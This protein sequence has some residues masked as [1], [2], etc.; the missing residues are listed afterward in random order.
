MLR[1]RQQAQCLVL[2]VTYEDLSVAILGVNSSS[3]RRMRGEDILISEVGEGEQV[4]HIF[5]VLDIIFFSS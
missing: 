3:K 2:G 5:C 1:L 4:I